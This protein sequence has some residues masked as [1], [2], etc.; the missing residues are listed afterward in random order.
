MNNFRAICRSLYSL[1]TIKG[2][3]EKVDIWFERKE[4][5]KQKAQHV[6]DM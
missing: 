5:E 6:R 3:L 4:H 2:Y 1:F